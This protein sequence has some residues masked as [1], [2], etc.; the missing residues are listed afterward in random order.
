M[1]DKK[2]TDFTELTT[3]ASGDKIPIVDVSDTTQGSSGTTKYATK[4]NFLADVTGGTITLTGNPP[5]AYI[6]LNNTPP[7]TGDDILYL[8]TG[9]SDRTIWSVTD[10][11]DMK[12][13]VDPTHSSLLI[14]GPGVH[15]VND[16]TGTDQYGDYSGVFWHPEGNAMPD[17]ELT[18]H[19]YLADGSLHRHFKIYTSNAAY[20]TAT[21][22]FTINYGVDVAT[23]NI[24][25]SKLVI[26]T[27]DLFTSENMLTL[28][29]QAG[30][31]GFTGNALYINNDTNTIAVNID[32]EA[33]SADTLNLD[34]VNTSGVL[35]D[36]NLTPGA[37]STAQMINLA[38]TGA[39]AS[40]GIVLAIDQDGAERA[41]WI[42]SE[43]T[44][45]YGIQVQGKYPI[46][47]TV[48]IT[49]GYGLEVTR[50][51][52]EVGSAYLVLFTED[53]TAN[54]SGLVK[55]QND[56]TGNGTLIDQNG[57][58]TALN[59]DTEATSVN[60]I[61]LDAVNTSGN[62]VDISLI[63]GAA[64]TAQ[65]LAVSNTGGNAST[66]RLV[67][68]QQTTTGDGL[69]ID[70]DGNGRA[71]DV[72]NAGTGVAI[73]VAQNGDMVAGIGAIYIYSDTVQTNSPLL[74]VE[75]DNASNAQ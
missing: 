61:N 44:T 6:E 24:D 66:G 68:F 72:Q 17:I 8:K 37:A 14:G 5:D 15:F 10:A 48:D 26:S 50:N 2:I 47:A 33:T 3:F 53:H 21:G 55:I 54:T 60:A 71:L 64:S 20:D 1:P 42:D 27:G 63:P 11:G 36:I 45:Q 29:A 34:A 7:A 73:N 22:R 16:A 30:G 57:N 62:V 51:I 70:Q 52:N 13:Y 35:F 32:T 56:G 59:I 67:Y 49:G 58:G 23:T 9:A 18:G 46:G 4:G 74:R 19:K 39:N 12:W 40:S 75:Q 31:A 28:N 65:A 69:E 25:N 41:I 43:S 38:N